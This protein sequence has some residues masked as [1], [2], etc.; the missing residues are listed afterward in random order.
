MEITMAQ[1]FILPSKG[2]V[3]SPVIDPHVTLRSMTTAEEMKRLSYTDTPYKTMAGIIDDCLITKL[4][5]SSYDLCSGDYEFLLHRLRM[6][7]YGPEY[8]LSAVCPHCGTKSDYSIDLQSLDVHMY[9]EDLQIEKDLTFSLPMSKKVVSIK[10]QTPRMLDE[11]AIRN[12]EM[13]RKFPEMKGDASLLILLETIVDKI[14]GQVL[15][16]AQKE[17]F[18]KSLPMLDTNYIIKKAEKANAKIG[19]DPVVEDTCVACGQ[20]FSFS[21]R[22]TSEFF[23]PTID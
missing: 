7:T 3:Y 23:G 14:D 22:F 2:L 16:E 8:K 9:D 21:F 13:K 19:I 1:D 15:D 4:P 5:I 20:Q 17:I 18:L 11:V 6:V 12:K 10:M